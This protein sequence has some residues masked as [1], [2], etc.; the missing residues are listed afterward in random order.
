MLSAR[1]KTI[2]IVSILVTILLSGSTE[3][4]ARTFDNPTNGGTII[5]N[6]AEATYR[7]D[8]GENFTTV[9]E[10][11]TMTVQTVVSL[12]VTPDETSPSDTLS[13]HPPAT[14]LLLPCNTANHS[15]T[16]TLTSA[17]I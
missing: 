17:D 1:S 4:W 9:S 3:L 11:V 8:A 7:N 12:A 15:A 6:R 13:P 14:R 10:T 16:F 5:S 2:A